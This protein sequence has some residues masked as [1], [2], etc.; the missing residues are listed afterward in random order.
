ML[1]PPPASF[2]VSFLLWVSQWYKYSQRV[3]NKVC[4]GL[5]EKVS[6]PWKRKTQW[7]DNV[8]FWLQKFPHLDVISETLTS[9]LKYEGRVL[10]W[11]HC[12]EWQSG[13]MKENYILCNIF[14]L[15][16]ILCQRPYPCTLNYVF[17]SPGDSDFIKIWGTE[18]YAHNYKLSPPLP[19]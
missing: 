8:L 10:G 15:F 16:F 12:W 14:K 17:I 9:S 19:S 1:H 3:W 13:Q 5:G 7:Q 11:S 4:E 18:F 6:S 2:E